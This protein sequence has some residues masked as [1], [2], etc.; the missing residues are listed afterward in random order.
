MARIGLIRGLFVDINGDGWVDFL[1]NGSDGDLKVFLNENGVISNTNRASTYGVEQ[2][3]LAL[4]Y[5]AGITFDAFDYNGDRSLD[6][7]LSS[8]TRFLEIKKN[9]TEV[10]ENTFLAVNVLGVNGVEDSR[11]SV[12]ELYDAATGLLVRVGTETQVFGKFSTEVSDHLVRFYGLDPA[13]TYDVVV[14]YLG[15]EGNG[16]TVVTGKTGLGTSKIAG[17][18]TEIVDTTL[19]AVTPGGKDVLHVSPENVTTATTGGTCTRVANTRTGLWVTKE[20]TCSRQTAHVL[21]RWV[22]PLT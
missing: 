16:V 2:G 10:A 8:N 13:K 21:A 18:F 11:Q 17:A 15:G 4:S 12:V 22:T 14:K 20:T 19:T 6:L 7:Y 9:F 5:T 3:D 1:G